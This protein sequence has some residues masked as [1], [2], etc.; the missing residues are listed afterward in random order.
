[1]NGAQGSPE[2]NP[3][4]DANAVTPTSA[5]TVKDRKGA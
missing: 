4:R 1:L 5:R 2:S 3:Q